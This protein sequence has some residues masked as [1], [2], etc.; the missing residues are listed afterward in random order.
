MVKEEMRGY[1]ASAKIEGIRGV[2][3]SGVVTTYTFHSFMTFIVDGR[4][5]RLTLLN[6]AFNYHPLF[7]LSPLSGIYLGPKQYLLIREKLAA[8]CI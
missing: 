2:Q 3:S 4:G 5:Q 7:S 1:T 6:G 8:V